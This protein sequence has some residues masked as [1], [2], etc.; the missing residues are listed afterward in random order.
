MDDV[1]ET[2]HIALSGET[3]L[4][5]SSTYTQENNGGSNGRY[6][7]TYRIDETVIP[8]NVPY[9]GNPHSSCRGENVVSKTGFLKV[10][11]ILFRIYVKVMDLFSITT[12]IRITHI[13]L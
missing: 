11:Q 7:H 12:L 2:I 3:S 10:T 6:Q 13:L 9:H 4:H 5:S 1:L 8:N